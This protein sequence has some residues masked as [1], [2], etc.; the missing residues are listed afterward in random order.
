MHEIKKII[1]DIEKIGYKVKNFSN[2]TTGINSSTFKI[3]GYEK[4]YLLKIYNSSK[5]NPINRL[6]HENRFLNFLK[7]C[8][9]EN[10]PQIIST[11]KKENWLLMS[12]IEGKKITE[13]NYDLCKEYLSFLVDIQ[14][15]R[16]IPVAKFILP[17]SEA[18]FHFKGH[19]KS[20]NH[21]ILLLEEKQQELLNLK[22]DSFKTLKNF[23]D[24]VKSEI[25]YLKLFQNDKN[26]DMDYILP[27]E[28]RIISQSDVGFHNMLLGKNY[29]YFFD[30]E[31]AGW[32][33][34]AKLFADL[35]MQPDYNIP[36][37]YLD[38]FDQYLK[39]FIFKENYN[40]DRLMFML[41][42]IRIKWS[43]IIMNPILN[44][45][46][47]YTDHFSN[48][49]KMKINKSLNY[50]ENSLMIIKILDKKIIFKT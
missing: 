4:K 43:L 11:N 22:E 46:E 8:K 37:K 13:V 29:V 49:F 38:I 25:N 40:S 3:E 21:R 23:L 20:I 32:D 6:E 45:T 26:I 10:V 41:K 31:Y 28:N 5:V 42:L 36:I 47:L 1:N 7:A 39:D 44:R 50:L 19:I 12:W 35:L 24:K 15:F 2:L 17:A 9:F 34:P 14:K 33:D 18:Y 27:E 16:G 30:F 48:L